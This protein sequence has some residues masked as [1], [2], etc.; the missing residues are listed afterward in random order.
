MYAIFCFIYLVWLLFAMFFIID[1]NSLVLHIWFVS[2]VC[3]FGF[4][5]L[6]FGWIQILQSQICTDLFKQ[7]EEAKVL[8]YESVTLTKKSSFDRLTMV[9]CSFFFLF[10]WF[11][12]KVVNVK[13]FSLAFAIKVWLGV[14]KCRFRCSGGKMEIGTLDWNY[15]MIQLNF[16]WLLFISFR[17][18]SIPNT[19]FILF[20]IFQSQFKICFAAV[21]SCI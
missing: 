17:Y 2:L 20:T 7:S 13:L 9:S 11:M 16:Q 5:Y 10:F 19:L 12:N 21:L 8:V 14:R 15:N 3:C 18:A 4:V 6:T 1:V